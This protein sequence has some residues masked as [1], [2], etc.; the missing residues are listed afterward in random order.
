VTERAI[1]RLTVPADHAVFAGHFP[2]F[3]IVPG[4]MLLDWVLREVSAVLGCERHRLRI[5][6]SKF[7]MPLLPDELAEL[8]IDESSGRC[9]FCIYRSDALLAA[10]FVEMRNE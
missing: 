4:V 7:F 8:R 2:G 6:D 9:S 1:A 5:R 3:P 10:G